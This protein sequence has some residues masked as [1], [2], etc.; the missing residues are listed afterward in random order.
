MSRVA[1]VKQQ[2]SSYQTTVYRI[3]L[4]YLIIYWSILTK[5]TEHRWTADTFQPLKKTHRLNWNIASGLIWYG[6]ANTHVSHETHLQQQGNNAQSGKNYSLQSFE[7]RAAREARFTTDEIH[8]IRGG[9]THLH[10]YVVVAQGKN[11]CLLAQCIPW[12]HLLRG[13]WSVRPDG[14]HDKKRGNVSNNA[15]LLWKEVQ[16]PRCW[17]K[18]PLIEKWATLAILSAKQKYNMEKVRSL[19]YRKNWILSVNNKSHF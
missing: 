9:V 2:P 6:L 14:S 13:L 11:S 4:K 1:A 8:H 19:V 17:G 10:T 15:S 18:K 12:R 5:Y 7:M 16:R 3:R